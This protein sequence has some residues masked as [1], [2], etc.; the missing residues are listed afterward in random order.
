MLPNRAKLHPDN[1]VFLCPDSATIPHPPAPSPHGEGEDD[2]KYVSY[3]GIPKIARLTPE[4]SYFDRIVAKVSI[5]G[6]VRV[7][8]KVAVQ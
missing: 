4:E 6:P 2:R 5:I 3:Q 8:L 1:S 7:G